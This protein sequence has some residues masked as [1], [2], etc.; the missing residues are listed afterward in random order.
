MRQKV[1]RST[2]TETLVQSSGIRVRILF[3]IT[4]IFTL[5]TIGKKEKDFFLHAL[6]ICFG[7]T[8]RTTQ[9]TDLA[10]RT[11]DDI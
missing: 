7:M 9:E 11:P 5:D 8:W 6:I 10:D 3:Y 4:A 2:R 1:K